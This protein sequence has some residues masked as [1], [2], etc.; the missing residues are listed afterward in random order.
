MVDAGWVTTS[1]FCRTEAGRTQVGS[2]KLMFIISRHQHAHYL[3]SEEPWNTSSVA[4]KGHLEMDDTG[5][6]MTK[7]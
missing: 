7:S 4:A 6:D 3:P 5:G 2:P 1:V